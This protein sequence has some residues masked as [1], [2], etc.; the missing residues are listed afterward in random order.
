MNNFAMIGKGIMF[1]RRCKCL[2]KPCDSLIQGDMGGAATVAGAVAA[3][4][5]LNVKINFIGLLP[6]CER[7]PP[8]KTGDVVHAMKGTIICFADT[9]S[10]KLMILCDILQNAADFDLSYIFDVATMTSEA[11]SAIG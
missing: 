10:E 5:K 2:L 6:I 7:M 8:S 11:Y 3:L 9:E 4:A 1:N